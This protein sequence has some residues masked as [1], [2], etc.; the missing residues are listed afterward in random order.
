M[1]PDY[2]SR[3][4]TQVQAWPAE[5]LAM[6][7]ERPAPPLIRPRHPA[8]VIWR[9]TLLHGNGRNSSPRPRLAQYVAMN[10]PP[11]AGQQREMA[12]RSRIL[13]WSACSPPD[14]DAFPG[15][16]RRIEE[17]RAEQASLS[18]LGRRLLG[19]DEWAGNP[20]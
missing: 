8:L 4:G 9:T 2:R 10:P 3:P 16:P 11:P 5:A 18:P 20:A 15:D 12:Q 7:T 1:I 17:Q 14:G 13:S 19:L 6:D